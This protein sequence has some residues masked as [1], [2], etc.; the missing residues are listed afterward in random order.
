MRLLRCYITVVQSQTKITGLK[1]ANG[2]IYKKALV[3]VCLK[4][5]YLDVKVF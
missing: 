3:D 1:S 5:K 2:A 4:V